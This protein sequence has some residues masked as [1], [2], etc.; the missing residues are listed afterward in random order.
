VSAEVIAY[1]ADAWD[2]SLTLKVEC[3][4]CHV[5]WGW[6]ADNKVNL[7]DLQD[8]AAMHNKRLH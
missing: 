6:S 3:L 4:D 5:E 1:S 8:R 7:Q 2:M